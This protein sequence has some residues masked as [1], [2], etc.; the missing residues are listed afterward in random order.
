ML[1]VELGAL[2]RPKDA[3]GTN[4][5]FP[6]T[7]L[8]KEVRRHLGGYSTFFSEDFIPSGKEQLLLLASNW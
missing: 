2:G 6:T 5:S 3:R 1:L 7:K 8:S 4:F